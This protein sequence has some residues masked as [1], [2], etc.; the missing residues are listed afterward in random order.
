MD[1]VNEIFEIENANEIIATLV[2]PNVKSSN[3]NLLA[4]IVLHFVSRSYQLFSN[5]KVHLPRLW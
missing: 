1:A 5:S 4:G 2:I 3:Y